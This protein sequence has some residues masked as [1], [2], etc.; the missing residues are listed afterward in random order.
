[1]SWTL[2]DSC[3]AGGGGTPARCE[4]PRGD[5][6]TPEDNKVSGVQRS[7]GRWV[8]HPPCPRSVNYWWGGSAIGTDHLW[9]IMNFTWRLQNPHL[10]LQ[11]GAEGGSPHIRSHKSSTVHP[12]HMICCW[13]SL[14]ELISRPVDLLTP[15]MSKWN[16]NVV[17]CIGSTT[18]NRKRCKRC[19]RVLFKITFWRN[20]RTIR[21]TPHTCWAGCG[22]MFLLFVLEEF[23]LVI[24]SY[25]Y[26]GEGFYL[27]LSSSWLS[28]CW[29]LNIVF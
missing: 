20:I 14:H 16:T 24:L 22:S 1:M 4:P 19:K 26:F 28:H 11:G 5:P 25:L 3:E 17:L 8:W 10:S 15:D 6:I 29:R 2:A 21:S 12:P 27:F 18:A 13:T 9:Q 23:N 7:T